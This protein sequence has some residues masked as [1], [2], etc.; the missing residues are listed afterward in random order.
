MWAAPHPLTLRQLQY[1]VTV[2]ELRS[3]RRA[4]E[5]CH[6]SQPALSA[7]IAELERALG[8]RLFERDRRRVLPTGASSELLDRARVLLLQADDL[9]DTARRREGPLVGTLRLGVLPTIAPY[10]LPDAVPLLRGRFERLTLHWFE[11]RTAALMAA[12]GAGELD[13][14]VVALESAIGGLVHEVIGRDEFVLAAPRGHPLARLRQPVTPAELDGQPLLLLTDGHC[15][16]DQALAFCSRAG[17]VEPGF[18]ATSL[19]TLAQMAAGGAGVTLLPRLAVP[20]EN[21]RGALVVRRFAP[22]VPSRT[23]ALVARPGSTIVP[24]LEPLARTL[25]E[26]LAG[27][28]RGG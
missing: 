15:F 24:A 22:P 6:V 12:L 14:A 25:R 7:Q 10:L 5:R 21:R 4:A 18:R 20:I 8:V 17:A 26:P 11:D 3:F 19:A 27:L 28:R 23:L 1:A 2:A 13:A 9:A 16:R